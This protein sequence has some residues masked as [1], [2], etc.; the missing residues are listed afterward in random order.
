M[1]ITLGLQTFALRFPQNVILLAPIPVEC[2]L[3]TGGTALTSSF[4]Y[5][6]LAGG[7]RIRVPGRGLRIS[8]QHLAGPGT[9]REL[10][11]AGDDEADGDR[12]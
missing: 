6:F 11:H 5:R 2:P 10:G 7:T 1:A 3:L 9:Q 12:L 8:F 4:G